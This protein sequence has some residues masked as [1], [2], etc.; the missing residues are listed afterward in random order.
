MEW[1]LNGDASKV[2]STSGLSEGIYFL[3]I[4]L[5]NGTTITEKLCSAN[6]GF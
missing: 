5:T 6:S 4:V 1:D 2:L 3:N